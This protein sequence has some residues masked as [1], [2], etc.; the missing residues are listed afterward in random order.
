MLV[1][2]AGLGA[3]WIIALAT[4]AA[5]GWFIWLVFACAVALLVMAGINMGIMQRYT[6]KPF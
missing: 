5:E 1:V 6:G 4:A 3:L 2:G